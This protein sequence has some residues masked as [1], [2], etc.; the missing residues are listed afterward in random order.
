MVRNDCVEALDIQAKGDLGGLRK[1]NK[2][3]EEA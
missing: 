1:E 2:E 3:I